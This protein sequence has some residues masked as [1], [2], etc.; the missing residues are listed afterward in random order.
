MLKNGGGAYI[1]GEEMSRVLGITRAAVWKYI[2]QLENDGYAVESARNN[3]YRLTASPD[4]LT[5][6]EVGDYLS[7]KVIGRKIV[8]LESV[9]STNSRAKELCEKGEPEGTVVVA[10]EQTGGKGTVGRQWLS[11][12]YRGIWMS[13]ILRPGLDLESIPALTMAA[14]AAVGKAVGGL[15]PALDAEI[16]V[17]WPNDVLLSGKKFCGVLTETSG[18]VDRAD[19]AVVGI[20]VNVNHDKD[21]LPRDL[22]ATSVRLALGL[23]ADRKILFAAILGAF[24]AEYAALKA[25]GTDGAAD[26]CRSRSCVLGRKVSFEQNGRSSAATAVDLDSRGRLVLRLENGELERFSS[27]QIKLL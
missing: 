13:V 12:A 11:K 8:H 10:E 19:Y 26:Y 14:C 17:K 5:L 27:G 15:F 4:I 24:E 18:E 7:T 9:G 3:G 20:G 21:E 23:C 16:G 6:D 25:G 2:K 1:S 22:E